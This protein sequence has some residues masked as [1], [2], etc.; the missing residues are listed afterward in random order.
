MVP[1]T[2]EAPSRVAA[3]ALGAV[4]ADAAASDSKTETR[5]AAAKA[6]IRGEA[7]ASVR[8]LA[9]RATMVRALVAV[10]AEARET[11]PERAMVAAARRVLQEQ[12][13]EALALERVLR[14]WGSACPRA[15]A[16][17]L[18]PEPGG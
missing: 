12:L 13:A 15:P 1:E 5:M 16:A 18:G 11:E 4:P 8:A 6:A 3:V 7:L 2:A 17:H 14:A 10:A 9:D